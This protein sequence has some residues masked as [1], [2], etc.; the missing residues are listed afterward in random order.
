MELVALGIIAG[1]AAL[2]TGVV[3]FAHKKG[4]LK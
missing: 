1:A 4:T 2:F 3:V